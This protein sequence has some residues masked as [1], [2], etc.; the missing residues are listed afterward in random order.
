M[1]AN[2]LDVF[3]LVTPVSK[4]PLLGKASL[5]GVSHYYTPTTGHMV[6]LLFSFLF[7]N[8]PCDKAMGKGNEK[9]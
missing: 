6:I 8:S 7:A 3:F 2:S 5:Y 4:L 1:S 9:N